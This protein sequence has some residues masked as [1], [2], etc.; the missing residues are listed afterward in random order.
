MRAKIEAREGV[1]ISWSQLSKAL[2]K[3]FRRRRPRHTLKGSQTAG[4]VARIGLR[5]LLR[6]LQAEAGDIILL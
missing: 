2:R 6:R 4:E 5:L 3:K 1:R